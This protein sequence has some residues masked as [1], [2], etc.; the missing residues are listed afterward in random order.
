MAVHQLREYLLERI[1]KP[2]IATNASASTAEAAR[3]RAHLLADVV[4]HGWP[5]EWVNAPPKFEED[6]CH[7]G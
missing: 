5:K 3:I 6:G 2:P 4:F 7:T 1:A